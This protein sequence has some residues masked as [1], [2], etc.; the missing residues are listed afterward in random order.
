MRV[1]PK[2]RL[3]IDIIFC[4]EK[5]YF[6]DG[7]AKKI[8][9][10]AIT[11]TIVINCGACGN[12]G[13]VK[14]G[15]DGVSEKSAVEKIKDTGSAAKDKI[16]EIA[17]SASQDVKKTAGNVKE[18]VSN[19][20][21]PDFQR[22]F[23]TAAG[24][25]EATVASLGGQKY[26]ND[27]AD[28]INNLE[29]NINKRV[30]PNNSF[31]IEKG[32]AAE[33]WHGGTYNVDAVAKGSEN[34]AVVNDSHEFAS[35]D[36]TVDDRAFSLK[37]YGTAEESAKQQ[38]QN[39]IQRYQK[40]VNETSSENPMTMGEWLDNNHID[41]KTESP[42]LYNAI[43]EG[44]L[45][46]V[47]ADQYEDAIDFLS[48]AI[49]KEQSKAGAN[50]SRVADAD[51][52]TLEH[53]TDRIKT[54]DG[55][56]SIPLTKEE[57]EALTK[58]AQEG[59]LDIS[60]FG[61][62]L[63]SSITAKYIAKQSLKAGATSAVIEAAFVLGPEIYEI[64]KHGIE[65]GELNEEEIKNVGKDGISS[66]AD[67]FLK[68]SISNAIV[69]MC[70]A[71]K[72]GAEYVN[73]SPEIVG[74]LTVMVIDAIR[75]GV[76]M[77]RGELPTAEYI[78]IMA[79]EIIVGAGALGASALVGLFFPGAT[80]AIMVGSLVGGLIV[81]SGYSYGK[82]YVVALIEH[83]KVDL[84]VP[85]EENAT[86]ISNMAETIK[87]KGNDAVAALKNI[88]KEA[89]KNVTIKMYDLTEMVSL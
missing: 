5:R 65:T 38:A 51:L 61:V 87:V 15:A 58:A 77:A 55:A 27:V 2:T 54:A 13:N 59:D 40:Y 63:D 72:L 80:L 88:G 10:L 57:S 66:A 81:S 41:L 67:G 17:D 26:V 31:K 11:F 32:P 85:I 7:V 37:N 60:K 89:A 6:M 71:G 8:I 86:V 44:Q 28:A 4:K 78:D 43:Y 12:A 16:E 62:T 70:R 49:A 22:G 20:S 29:N 82:T 56:E 73:A 24:F 18:K 84:L 34:R 46:I 23:E 64:I 75:Y 35:S 42:E 69:I 36:I 9:A 52:E 21:L 14:P 33:E 68:G 79:E 76:V 47:P 25:F 50:R 48:K 3:I 53:L 1:N 83:S 19:L 39:Y 30:N 74:T 45:R